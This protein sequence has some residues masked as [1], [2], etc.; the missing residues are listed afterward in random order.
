MK[1]PKCTSNKIKKVKT[2]NVPWNEDYR[3]KK[4]LSCGHIFYTAE[5][6]VEPN[7]RFRREWELYGFKVDP[8]HFP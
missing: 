5:F 7:K 8:R 2:V 6:E 3:K 1:C 4:C